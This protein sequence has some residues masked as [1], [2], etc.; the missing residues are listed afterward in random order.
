MDD[1]TNDNAEYESLCPS[2]VTIHVDHAR[3]EPPAT[4]KFSSHNGYDVTLGNLIRVVC[5][6]HYDMTGIILHVDFH[7]ASME[8]QCNDFCVR[9]SFPLPIIF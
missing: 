7:K 1:D 9:I 3:I 2:S 8:I 6:R 5:R 4:L